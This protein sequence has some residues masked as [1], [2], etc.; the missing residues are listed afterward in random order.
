[1][2]D[3]EFFSFAQVHVDTTGQAGVK[4]TDRP[5]DVDAL[6]VLGTVLLEDRCVL[7]SIFVGS[8]G[9]I[10]VTYTAIPGRWWIGMIVRDLAILDDEMVGEYPTHGLVEA[11]ADGLLRNSEVIPCLGMTSIQFR[12]RLLQAVQRNGCRVRLEVRSRTVAFESVAP[13][14]WRRYLPLELYFGLERGL[15]QA[16]LDAVSSGLDVATQVHDSSQS[17]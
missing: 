8:R 16:N 14:F 3:F 13:S 9:S 17:R 5:H 11:A 10:D 15:G 12:H 7:H 2:D 4:A 1:M 6:E